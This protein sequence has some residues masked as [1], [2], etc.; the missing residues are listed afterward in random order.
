MKDYV[1]G[2]PW[3]L[4]K[5]QYILE[6]AYALFSERGIVP[7][8]ISDI[9][10][11]SGVGRVT[12]FRYFTTKLDLVI[13]VGAWQWEKYIEAHNNSLPREALERITAA[14][15][16]RFF[17]DS[18][19]DLYRNHPDIL[20]FNYE[21]NNFL[22]YEAAT[23][24]QRQPY[25]QMVSGL[26]AQFHQLYQRGMQDGTLRDDTPER[27]MFSSIFHIML[28]AATR[29]AIGLVIVYEDDGNPES[30]LEM[31]EEMLFLR[32]TKAG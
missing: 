29:Y 9:A 21:F 15:W 28:A 25:V 31:L 5:Q 27:T 1:A 23:E 10:R 4:E 13:A 2:K 19:L 26:G 22:H 20:R 3:K 7:V 32:F 11:A 17:L 30:E 6:T 18:F 12:V 8:T 14:Q 24:V 16:L